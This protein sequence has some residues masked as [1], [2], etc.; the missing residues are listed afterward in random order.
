MKKYLKEIEISGIILMLLGCFIKWKWTVWLCGL[1]LILWLIPLVYKAFHWE[2]YKR[3]N[4]V[5]IVIMTG[6]IIA[7]MTIMIVSK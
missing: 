4:I 5:N 7:I 2:E 3:D 1:G 6:A